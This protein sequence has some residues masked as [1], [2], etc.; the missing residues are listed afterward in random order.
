LQKWSEKNLL[1]SL[2][3]AFVADLRVAGRGTIAD[4]GAGWYF[5]RRR[6]G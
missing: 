3:V 5:D 2:N 6:S 1:D 4:S